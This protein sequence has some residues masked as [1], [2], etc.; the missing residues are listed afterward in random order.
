MLL[1]RP[2]VAHGGEPTDTF[3]QKA[4]PCVRWSTTGYAILDG[5]ERLLITPLTLNAP[6]SAAR[7]SICEFTFSSKLRQILTKK[8]FD[9]WLHIPSVPSVTS[10]M[11]K[12]GRFR[13]V[14]SQGI[15]PEQDSYAGMAELYFKD[16][17]GW[18]HYKKLI[19]ADSMEQWMK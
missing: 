10:V 1:P 19:H 18:C 7:S 16:L 6:F 13:H 8:V 2:D 15:E 4:W 9:H 17:D 5:S 12:A 3:Q 14:A 11:R